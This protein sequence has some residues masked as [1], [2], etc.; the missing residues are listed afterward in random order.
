MANEAKALTFE[1]TKAVLE[2]FAQEVCKAY[3][4]GLE[5]YDALASRELYKSVTINTVNVDDNGMLKVSI[6]LMGYWKY[7]EAGRKAYGN[8]YKGHL[9]PISAIEKWIEWKHI[10]PNG[11][12]RGV[13]SYA[14]L[15]PN[16]GSLDVQKSTSN[17][18]W[19]IATNIAK[20]GID[21]KP[22]LKNSVSE[23]MEAFRK[24]IAE[25]LAKDVSGTFYTIVGE[26]WSGVNL[27]K[28]NGAWVDRTITDTLVL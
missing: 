17:L 26:L 5:K 1:N 18:A 10:I 15:T 6:N 28:E 12:Q 16:L 19:A 14:S 11:T 24:L 23:T 27:S 21:P 8:D 3:Q 25:A 7:V 4:E 13:P 9:P 20:K 2:Q 22:I